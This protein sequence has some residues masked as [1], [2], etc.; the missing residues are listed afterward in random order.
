MY[1]RASE[2]DMTQRK[3]AS[4]H[5]RSQLGFVLLEAL[6]AI[7]IFSFGILAIMGLQGAA[8]NDVRDAKYR[9][10]AALLANQIIGNMWT[11]DPASNL[12][13]YALN[14]AGTACQFSGG[15]AAPGGS[16]AQANINGWLAQ[17]AANLPGTVANPPQ[18]TV[19]TTSGLVTVTVC[20]QTAQDVSTGAR[21]NHTVTAQIRGPNA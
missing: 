20:W 14:T 13:N 5:P 17:L 12:G 1:K 9:S 4:Q 8:I 21:H 3:H 16:Q 18:I 2:P 10:D 15:P 6:I 19:D 7:L 11:D